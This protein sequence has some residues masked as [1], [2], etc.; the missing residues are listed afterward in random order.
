MCSFA[1]DDV[2]VKKYKYSSIDRIPDLI[3]N[4][5]FESNLSKVSTFDEVLMCIQ[6]SQ[7]LFIDQLNMI[8]IYVPYRFLSIFFEGIGGMKDYSK[9][10]YIKMKN[11]SIDLPYT[12]KDNAISLSLNWVTDMISS[13]TKFDK[14]IDLKKGKYINV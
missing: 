11:L 4:I 2:L 3:K 6:S 12:I 8:T 13:C 14:I 9:N 1:W 5:Y 10:E 7:D